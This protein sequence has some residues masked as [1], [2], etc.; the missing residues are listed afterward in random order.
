MTQS[1]DI[2]TTLPQLSATGKYLTDPDGNVVILRGYNLCSK[3]AQSPEELGFGI[4]NVKFLRECGVTVVRLGVPWANTQPYLLYVD[5]VLQYN[6]QFL[7]SIKR[8]IKLLSEFGIYTLVDFHQDAY[9]TPWGFGAPSWAL[10]AGGTNT[11]NFPWPINTFGGNTGDTLYMIPDPDSD[12]RGSPVPTPIETDLNAAFDAFWTNKPVSSV[13]INQET[14]KVFTLWEAYGGMLKFVSNYL[15]DQQGNILGYDPI[16]E[17]EPGAQW[18]EGYV[19][20]TVPPAEG[21]NFFDFANGFPDFDSTY[22]GPFYQQCAIPSLRAGHPEAMI[23]FE[24][25]IYFD[26]NAPS[27]IPDLTA[28][29]NVGFNFHNYDAASRFKAPITNALDYQSAYN[30]P[31]LCSEF[32][33]TVKTSHIQTVADL[34]DTNMLSSIFWAWF[35]N[36]QFNFAPASTTEATDPR[37]MGV[38]QDMWQDLVPTNVNQRFLDILTRVYPRVV[39]GTP[40]SFSSQN[41]TFILTYSTQLPNGQTA[42]GETVIVVPAASYPDPNDF[43]VSAPGANVVNKSGGIVEIVADSPPPPTITVTISRS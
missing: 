24:P 21:G 16:N 41:G 38:V 5:G 26:Y 30:V 6:M 15:S 9:S 13:T 18:V 31:L 34:N 32:G 22:L 17:P 1:A 29:G 36:A 7:A 27:N 35:N 11:P 19:P 43:N 3:T 20:P 8:T 10:V 42:T 14:G 12:P 25:N 37:L 4:E 39:A 28:A 23:W 33:G 2:Q 40:Q